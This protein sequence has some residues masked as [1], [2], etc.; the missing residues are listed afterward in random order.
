VLGLIFL[1]FF[2]NPTL[3]KNKIVSWTSRLLSFLIIISIA[4]A[5]INRIP[6]SDYFM[7]TRRIVLPFLL[8]FV[9]L[10]CSKTDLRSV[11]K[12][13]NYLLLINV[14]IVI[15]QTIYREKC[16]LLAHRSAWDVAGG[17]FS[18]PQ[19]LSAFCVLY[20]IYSISVEGVKTKQLVYLSPLLFTMSG[21][22]VAGV[23]V[24]I[25]LIMWEIFRTNILK[26]IRF[27]FVIMIVLVC[28]EAG[29]KRI[30]GR[31]VLNY[32]TKKVYR[33]VMIN[34]LQETYT[35]RRHIGRIGGLKIVTRYLRDYSA[36]G[37][38]LGA[39]PG[40]FSVSEIVPGEDL[41]IN[42]FFS[43]RDVLARIYGRNL[44]F[45]ILS[46]FGI[47]SLI[48]IV[49]YFLSIIKYYYRNRN[50]SGRFHIILSTVFLISIIFYRP[51][52]IDNRIMFIYFTFLAESILS[53]RKKLPK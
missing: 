48:A 34:K 51:F 9:L 24:I 38:L 4:S 46:E 52:L 30:F 31:G 44:V 6:V 16:M 53:L 37:I 36:G 20:C 13:F 18:L 26:F 27:V 21:G 3:P 7:G 17:T 2:I 11:I 15:I 29:T 39:G 45:A 42:E 19:S 25:G 12:G 10:K 49:S 28:F 41:Y 32:V 33:E 14:I 35:H 40:A 47:L 23:L 22:V 50:C 1:L 43:S 8:F 5:V